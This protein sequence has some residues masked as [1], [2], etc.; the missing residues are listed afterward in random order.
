MP[1]YATVLISLMLLMLTVVCSVTGVI[2]WY[3][4]RKRYTLRKLELEAAIQQSATA[5]E[6]KE[7]N[8]KSTGV[9]YKKKH[10]G[11]HIPQ[12][13]SSFHLLMRQGT[14]K[15]IKNT[16]LPQLLDSRL[17]DS[18]SLLS[19]DSL[20]TDTLPTTPSPLSTVLTSETNNPLNNND[21][22]LNNTPVATVKPLS[23]RLKNVSFQPT[24]TISLSQFGKSLL[25]ASDRKSFLPISIGKQD[26]TPKPVSNPGWYERHLARK[27]AMDAY[28]QLYLTNNNNST[29]AGNNA[30]T[31]DGSDINNKDAIDD[32]TTKV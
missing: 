10:V 26:N 8:H 7:K 30:G 14:E 2:V 11:R 21:S 16:K 9:S 20:S 22:L 13:K 18:P 6:R 19:D 17:S 31:I 3:G 15:H 28:V 24:Q 32:N 25:T 5:T 4:M 29:N 12:N 27:Q 23:I 1:V